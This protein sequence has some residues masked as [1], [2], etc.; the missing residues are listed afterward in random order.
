MKEPLPKLAEF[1]SAGVLFVG[2][3]LNVRKLEYKQRK[4]RR[5][6]SE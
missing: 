2:W 4:R 1:Q 5:Y 3:H 6:S